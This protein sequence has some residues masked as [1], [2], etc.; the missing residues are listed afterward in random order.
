[1]NP[2]ERPVCDVCT[3]PAVN[4]A[5]PDLLSGQELVLPFVYRSEPK[6]RRQALDLFATYLQRHPATRIISIRDFISDYAK[7]LK[8]VEQVSR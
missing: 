4:C 7:E 8:A 3:Q 5:C 1:M 2:L 6:T